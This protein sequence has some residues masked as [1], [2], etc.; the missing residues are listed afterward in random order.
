MR[1]RIFAVKPF[2]VHDGN[3]IRTTVFLRV[4]RCGADGAIIR[5]DCLLRRNSRFLHPSVFLA[6]RA[7]M[8]VR[9]EPFYRREKSIERAVPPAASVRKRVLRRPLW[10][11]GIR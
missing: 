11:R 9:R 7:W 5:R 8:Y 4:A 3:G 1:G 10:Y 6:A 2:A